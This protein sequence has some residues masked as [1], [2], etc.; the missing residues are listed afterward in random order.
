MSG[1]FS[2]WKTRLQLKPATLQVKGE[3]PS[4]A[5]FKLQYMQISDEV[6]Q[7]NKQKSK[8][9]GIW[10]CYYFLYKQNK[11]IQKTC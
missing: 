1:D 4:C 7:T 6:K 8:F 5:T 2:L 11:D 9:N 10:C 3:N